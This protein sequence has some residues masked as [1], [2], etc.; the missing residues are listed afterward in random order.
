MQ[1]IILLRLMATLPLLLAVAFVSFGLVRLA[2]GD[3]LSEL[4]AQPN[5]SAETLARW[6][7]HYALDAPWYAQFGRWLMNVLRGDFGYSFACHCAAG[8][9]V[10]QRLAAT[11]TLAVA[12]LVLTLI[13]ALPLGWLAARR[14]GWFGPTLDRLSSVLATGLLATPSFLL[15]VLALV[16]AAKTGWFPLGGA[17]SFDSSRFSSIARVGD[18]LHH[19]FL[20]ASVLALRLAPAYFR[21]WR[22]SLLETITQDF[23]LTARAKGLPESRVWLKHAGANALNPLLTMLGHSLGSLLSGAFIVEAVMS[24]PGLGSLTVSSLLSRDLNVMV[25]CMI[26]AA[27]LLALG[28]LLADLLLWWTDPRLRQ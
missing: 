25:A 21:Q 23:T 14:Q 18:F 19:L 7:E 10:A 16:F 27:L 26:C 3:F 1:K 20:P 28:N 2:P 9:L 12:A 15:A 5:I 24:W 22:A 17:Q 8:P 4:S 6:R 13:C 11:A